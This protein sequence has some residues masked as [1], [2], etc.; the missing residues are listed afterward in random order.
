MDSAILPV[1][2]RIL[3]SLNI[4]NPKAYELAHQ[5]AALTG[6]TLTSVVV[7]ALQ[8]RLEEEKSKLVGVKSKSER[9]MEFATR[10]KA[11]MD[12]TFRSEDHTT[13]LFDE[14]GLPF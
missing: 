6:E 9:M 10:F 11:G 7:A 14:D 3:V 5:I 12:P 2:G 4:K 1:G 8:Q 13:M